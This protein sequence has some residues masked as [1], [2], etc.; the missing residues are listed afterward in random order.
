MKRTRT[1][2]KVPCQKKTSREKHL[3]KDKK[4]YFSVSKS[5]SFFPFFVAFFSFLFSLFEEKCFALFFSCLFLLFF[6]LE[7]RRVSSHGIPNR[8]LVC[9]YFSF[10]FFFLFDKNQFKFGFL[11]FEKGGLDLDHVWKSGI[12]GEGFFLLPFYSFFSFL[13]SLFSLFPL[14][15]SEE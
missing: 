2:K 13:F 8:N 3:Q 12:S 15:L 5:L 1:R 9:L 14:P 10:T 7:K 6:V 4:G 11:F